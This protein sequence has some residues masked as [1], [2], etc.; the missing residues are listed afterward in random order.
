LINPVAANL[1]KYYPLPNIEG[2]GGGTQNNF[3]SNQLR[4][5]DYRGWL[6][7]IDHRISSNQSI[8]GKYYHS[9]NPEDRQDWAGVVNGFP[10]TQGFEYRTNDA[11]ISTT[12]IR[13]TR[14]SCST[15][16]V[17][18]NRSY[19]NA[20]PRNRSTRHNS[21]SRHRHSQPCAVTSTS[22]AS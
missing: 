19:R 14:I 7:R 2:V 11:A 9:F 4:H 15:L 1:I 22:R 3:F 17:S 5:Q 18:L 10:I 13:L 12:P 6:A 16:R 8:F 21:A 20:A